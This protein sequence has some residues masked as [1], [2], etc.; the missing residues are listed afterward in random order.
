[1]ELFARKTQKPVIIHKSANSTG[2][3]E[4]DLKEWK[5]SISGALGWA[6]LLVI[7]VLGAG[8]L[9]GKYKIFHKIRKRVRRKRK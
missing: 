6:G 3:I 5:F 1:M 2:K 9:Q 8:Y 7:L 4:G